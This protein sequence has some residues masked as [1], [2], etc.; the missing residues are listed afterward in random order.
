M[1]S[2]IVFPLQ[3]VGAFSGTDIHTLNVTY[4]LTIYDFPVR[5]NEYPLDK[6]SNPL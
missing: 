1:S 3:V 2:D 6:M 5:C 4:D